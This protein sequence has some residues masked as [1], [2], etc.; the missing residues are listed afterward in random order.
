VCVY[1]FAIITLTFLRLQRASLFSIEIASWNFF[2]HKM[3]VMLINGVLQV[4]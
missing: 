3:V 1:T 4:V 2:A